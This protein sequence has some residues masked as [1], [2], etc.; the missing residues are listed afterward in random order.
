MAV[1][2]CH[3]IEVFTN[4]AWS[5]AAYRTDDI[6]SKQAERARNDREHVSL[7]PRLSADQERSE[8]LNH[9]DHFD[10]LARKAHPPH[11]SSGDLRS[12]QY[13]DDSAHR[14]DAFGVLQDGYHDS[15]QCVVL[16]N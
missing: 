7:R 4:R 3:E 13:A 6:R 8:I 10:A 11:P 5:I 2:T 15:Q 12:V 9:L 14:Y 16:E 1:Q